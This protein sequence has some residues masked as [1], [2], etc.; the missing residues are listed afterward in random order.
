MSDSRLIRAKRESDRALA[1]CRSRI[2]QLQRECAVSRE[3]GT[4]LAMARDDLEQKIRNQQT[5]ITSLE[6]L[7]K[8]SQEELETTKPKLHKACNSEERLQLALQEKTEELAGWEKKSADMQHTIDVLEQEKIVL[9][10]RVRI[11]STQLEELEIRTQTLEKTMCVL[12]SELETTKQ[13]ESTL[14]DRLAEKGHAYDDLREQHDR[15]LKNLRILEQKMTTR[16]VEAAEHLRKIEIGGN[17]IS[18][19]REQLLVSQTATKDAQKAS[20]DINKTVEILEKKLQIESDERAGLASELQHAQIEKTKLENKLLNTAALLE[21]ELRT[22]AALQGNLGGLRRSFDAT[23]A[24]LQQAREHVDSLQEADRI[25][26]TKLETLRYEKT[27]LEVDLKDIGG[28]LV[29]LRKDVQVKDTELARV[30]SANTELQEKL[31]GAEEQTNSAK[32]ELEHMHNLKRE[33]DDRHMVEMQKSDEHLRSLETS[34][35]GLRSIVDSSEKLQASL[36]EELTR[37]QSSTAAVG[38]ELE[39]A[40]RSKAEIESNIHDTQSQLVQAQNDCDSLEAQVNELLSDLAQSCRSKSCLE[41]RM[42]VLTSEGNVLRNRVAELESALREN[43]DSR[44]KAENALSMAHSKNETSEANLGDLRRQAHE[45]ETIKHR[46]QQD[47]SKSISRNSDLEAQLCFVRECLVKTG[48]ESKDIQAQLSHLQK[49]TTTLQRAKENADQALICMEQS[50]GKLEEQLQYMQSQLHDALS[51]MSQSESRLASNE[52]ELEA[53]FR[54]KATVEKRLEQTHNENV[55]LEEEFALTRESNRAIKSQLDNTMNSNGGLEKDLAVARAEVDQAN[56][57]NSKLQSKM[58]SLEQQLES[59]RQIKEKLE[60]RLSEAL[61]VSA[62][63][64]RSISDT[65]SRLQEVESHKSSLLGELQ[66]TREEPGALRREKIELEA[67]EDTSEKEI[68]TVVKKCSS[69]HLQVAELDA[70][71]A[72]LVSQLSASEKELEGLRLTHCELEESSRITFNRTSELEVELKA[73]QMRLEIAE[74]E[75]L[76]AITKLIMADRELDSLKVT[77][78]KLEAS[79]QE[80]FVRLAA[81]EEELNTAR[82]KNADL[83]AFL[84]RVQSDMANAYSAVEETER[85]CR[86]FVDCSEAKLSAADNSKLRSKRR[87]HQRNSELEILISENSNLHQQIGMQTREIGALEKGKNKLADDLLSK[88][89][90][91]KELGSS[92]GERMR[93]MNAAYNDLRRKFEEQQRKHQQLRCNHDTAARLEAELENKLTQI[94][95]IQNKREAYAAS[96]WA[97]E[98]EV[99]VLRNDKRAFEMLISTLQEKIRHLE[100]LEEWKQPSDINPSGSPCHTTIED[101]PYDTAPSSPTSLHAGSSIGPSSVQH[102]RPETRAST[103]SP[104]EDLDMWARHVEQVRIQRDEA[105]LQLKGMKKSQHNLKKTSRNTDAQLHRLEKENKA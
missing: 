40:R 84:E 55:R 93:S 20:A 4:L 2:E 36:C 81:A 102:E 1:T 71:S 103:I 23:E 29:K 74:S 64:E 50:H 10:E 105:A 85:S 90:Y 62:S 95:E 54:A 34:I 79:E 76:K 51:K 19:L 82:E 49:K 57:Q 42:A 47:L 17:V 104:E 39:E 9:E 37:V 43:Y 3:D 25:T 13:H 75:N 8:R 21:Q 86:E 26:R 5:Q 44:I 24:N 88:E 30:K 46:L 14:Q 31:R 45:S 16:D 22:K 15:N 27:T 48:L 77:R 72:E 35:L 53:M 41:E 6:Y 52:E 73:A 28:L 70:H 96:F 87:L 98:Q 66:E 83:E 61:K 65:R 91:I 33:N 100:V 99:E 11:Q 63:T 38:V 78:T 94:E 60:A 89:K 59:Y 97:L 7:R 67:K 32:K 58:S 12:R 80:L 92:A 68:E 69:L 18:T 101:E 56:M